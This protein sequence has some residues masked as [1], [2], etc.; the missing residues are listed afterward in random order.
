MIR[1]GALPRPELPDGVELKG[2]YPE[3]AI[4]NG[5]DPDLP[6]LYERPGPTQDPAAD[7]VPAQHV[8]GD[9]N[10]AEEEHHSEPGLLRQTP[11]PHQ[12]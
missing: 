10:A 5:V 2:S 1:T 6:A 11:A 8:L 9:L 7:L 12:T 4:T 3:M